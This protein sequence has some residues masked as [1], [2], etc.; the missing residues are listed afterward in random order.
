MIWSPLAGGKLFL[1]A[2][3]RDEQTSRVVKVLST[4]A[5]E[6]GDNVTIDQVAY[7]FILMHPSKPVIVC[8]TNDMP[9]L[10]KSVDACAVRLDKPQW[11]RILEASQGSEVP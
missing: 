6:I 4:I 10:G 3:K 8:G 1:P 11:F 5:K 2:D 9:R 7:A